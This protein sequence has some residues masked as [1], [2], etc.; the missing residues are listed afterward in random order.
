MTLAE[1]GEVTLAA[2]AA[3]QM[4]HVGESNDV[5][6][7]PNDAR[8]VRDVQPGA[9]DTGCTYRAGSPFRIKLP[10]TRVVSRTGDAVPQALTDNGTIPSVVKL[11]L[12]VFDVDVNGRPGAPPEVDKVFFN[13]IYVGNLTGGDNFWKRNDF[14]VPISAVK[15]ATHN[16]P[17]QDPTPGENIAERQGALA[18]HLHPR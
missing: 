1:P 7:Q 11:R 6:E 12:P 14:D 17:G 13:N 15:F 5:F 3:S 10:V 4:Q 9:L 18:D 2:A 8:Y 16:G